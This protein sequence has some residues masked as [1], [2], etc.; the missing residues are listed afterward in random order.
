MDDKLKQYIEQTQP[1]LETWVKVAED[2]S[3]S[4]PGVMNILVANGFIGE[5]AKEA[6]AKGIQDNPAEALTLLRKI[7]SKVIAQEVGELTTTK[8]AANVRVDGKKEADDRFA[9]AFG[10]LA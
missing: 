10:V 7:A 3:K 9:R 5:D 8:K 4:L 2:T 6:T 1:V